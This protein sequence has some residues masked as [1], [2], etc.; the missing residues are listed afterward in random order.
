M[1]PEHGFAIPALLILGVAAS[2][3]SSETTVIK[4]ASWQRPE[5]RAPQAARE[6]VV[7]LTPRAW[8]EYPER[9]EALP[10]PS[11]PE[12]AVAPPQSLTLAAKPK[13]GCP[14]PA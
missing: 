11:K 8:A 9:A 1:K 3:S 6:Q 10:E 13:S 12:A 7:Q 2:C 5:R 14:S 4:A